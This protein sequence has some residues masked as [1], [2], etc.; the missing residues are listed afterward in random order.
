M[1]T[2]FGTN[3]VQTVKLW[4]KM[5]F[6]ETLNRMWFKRLVSAGENAIIRRITELEKQAGDTVKYDLLRAMTQEGV[7]GDDP[8]EGFEEG[9]TYEQ[10]EVYIDQR[11]IGHAFR[12]MSQQRT[13]HQL[14]VDARSNLAERF[15]ELYD[16]IMFAQLCGVTGDAA[17][18][19]LT[20]ATAAHAGNVLQDPDGSDSDHFYDTGG[21]PVNLKTDVIDY[22]VERA[23]TI[24]PLIKPASFEGADHYI[25]IM[26]PYSVTDLRTDTTA[27][28]WRDI[29]SLVQV[30]G[31]KNPLFTGALGVWNN[32]ILHS[33]PRL[34]RTSTG[35]LSHQLFLGSGAGVV[36]WGNAYSK[37]DQDGPLGGDNMMSW[38]ERK[39]D[40]G[41]E[42]G[43]AAGAIFGV[44][45]CTFGD[46]GATR[47]GMI[48]VDVTAV[49]ST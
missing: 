42:R 2:E 18:W 8:M 21:S 35:T 44:K 40:Y 23:T 25:Y 33:T 43:V 10:D 24:K 28:A 3:D 17:G 30:R 22:M 5:L 26:H 20:A 15:S 9:L 38:F 16:M 46:A 4:S 29:V 19:V 11:R 1:V 31:E 6:R 47:F 13:V 14:R 45:P 49:A 39:K 36:A 34:P 7:A 48:R 32:V 37:L 27:A 12:R 41:N